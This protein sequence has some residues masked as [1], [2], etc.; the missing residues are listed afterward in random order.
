MAKIKYQKTL[1]RYAKNDRP[2]FEGDEWYEPSYL[3]ITS[4][5][6]IGWYGYTF[7]D[8]VDEKKVHKIWYSDCSCG[9]DENDWSTEAIE[10][11]QDARE[12]F[13]QFVFELMANNLLPRFVDNPY[14]AGEKIEYKYVVEGYRFE[15]NIIKEILGLEKETFQDLTE[16]EY[17]QIREKLEPTVWD[18]FNALYKNNY[19]DLSEIF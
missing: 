7:E 10:A 4:N 1:V 18:K 2:T 19:I 5:G 12:D 3:G 17:Q 6:E 14:R 15:H 16:E 8:L 13:K 9:F 11:R